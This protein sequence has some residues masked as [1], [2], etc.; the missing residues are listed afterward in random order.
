MYEKLTITLLGWLFLSVLSAQ[1]SHEYFDRFTSDDGL[2]ENHVNCI[3][4]DAKGFMWFG[5]FDGLNR[6]DGYEVVTYKPHPNDSTSISGILIYSL[7]EDR[8][9]NLWVGT[10]GNGLNRFDPNT[11]TFLRIGEDENGEGGLPSNEIRSLL[12]DRRNRLWVGS[13]YGL[14]ML[15]LNAWEPGTPP[16]F[17]QFALRGQM[18]MCLFESKRGELWAGTDVGLFS[19]REQASGAI[20]AQ[21]VPVTANTPVPTINSITELPGDKLVLGGNGGLFLQ[22]EERTFVRSNNF[23]IIDL[24][25]DSSGQYLWA[26]TRNGLEVFRATRGGETLRSEYRFLNKPQD[27]SSLSNNTIDEVYVD[28]SGMVWVGTFGGGINRYDPNRKSFQR[29]NGK[30]VPPAMT[31][32]SIRAIYQSRD[33][34]VWVG[35]VGGGLLVSEGSI[36]PGQPVSFREVSLPARVYSILEVKNDRGHYLYVGTDSGPGLY[37]INL[38]D[39]DLRARAVSD[40]TQSVFTALEDSRGYLWFGTYSGGLARWIPDASAPDGYRK[41]RF[42]TGEQENMLPS[43]IIRSLMEDRRGNLWVGTANGLAVL[44]NDE[45]ER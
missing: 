23:N 22:T 14:S 44:P 10:T 29:L 24:A 32:N 5:T 37:E 36:R 28:R 2:S 9:G 43:N 6:F 35:T 39:S 20:S 8:A 38:R 30:D 42:R 31:S 11:E 21:S 26:G 12:V 3:H 7:A 25:V 17:R 45:K 34:R 16:V 19:L 33:D 13:S 27:R 1:V 41:T 18:I 15:D 40:L 4:Q